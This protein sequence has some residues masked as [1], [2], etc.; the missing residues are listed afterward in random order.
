MTAKQAIKARCR[1]CSGAVCSFDDC[2]LK[3]LAKAKG[4][5]KHGAASIRAYCKWCLNGH[6]FN[7]CASPDCTIF[8]FR[9]ER[10]EASKT[11]RIC[12]K[13]GGTEGVKQATSKKPYCNT[14]PQNSPNLPLNIT[15]VDVSEGSTSKDIETYGKE[16]TA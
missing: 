14:I 16:E 12:K 6:R 4:K 11:P 8:Q 15:A 13:T 10:E 5:I 9:K 2:A 1:D 7:I 3:G